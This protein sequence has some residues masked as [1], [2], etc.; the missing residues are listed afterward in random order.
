MQFLVTLGAERLGTPMCVGDWNN[1]NPIC[2]THHVALVDRATAE[3]QLG[4]LEPPYVSGKCY[5][6]ES[7]SIF[8]FDTAANDA[9]REHGVE[10]P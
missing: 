3:A 10:L 7:G 4:K 9:I 8:L 5:C 6:P 2:T 1:G